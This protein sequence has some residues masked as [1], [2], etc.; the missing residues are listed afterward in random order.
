MQTRDAAQA[1]VLIRALCDVRNKMLQRL[2]WL[3]KHEGGWRTAALH[4]DVDEAQAHIT[5][6]HRRY[7][8]GNAP[9]PAE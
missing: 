7:L 1:E 6:L 4:R 3:E 5:N 9:P 8:I 2:Q